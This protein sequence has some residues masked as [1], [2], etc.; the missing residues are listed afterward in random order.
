MPEAQLDRFLMRIEM[1]YPDRDAEVAIL[2]SQTSHVA[3]DELDP[4]V[5]ADEVVA[6]AEAITTVHIAASLRNYIV[7]LADATRRHHDLALGA[8]PRGALA[9]QRA[10]RALAATLGRDYV[11]PDDVKRVAPVVLEH[12]LLLTPDAELRGRTPADVLDDVLASVPVP[13]ATGLT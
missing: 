13:G 2:E 1:G 10:A 6:A 12:R 3:V 7:D 8:S 11:M 4:V 5:S 9:L